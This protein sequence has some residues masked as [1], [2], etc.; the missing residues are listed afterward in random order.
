MWLVRVEL[1]GACFGFEVTSDEA[2]APHLVTTVA[3][4]TLLPLLLML[5][6]GGRRVVDTAGQCC[7][8]LGNAGYP[9]AA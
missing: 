3:T 1:P 6:L 5:M 7:G 9:S 4:T 8:G 2:D